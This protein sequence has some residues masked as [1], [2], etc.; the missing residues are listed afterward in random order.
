MKSKIKTTNQSVGK[1]GSDP[2]SQSNSLEIFS[3]DGIF[4]GSDAEYN[5]YVEAMANINKAINLNRIGS[6]RKIV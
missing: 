5:D 4:Q 1:V 2:L 3:K 6:I